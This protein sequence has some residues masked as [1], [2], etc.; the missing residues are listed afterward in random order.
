MAVEASQWLPM[1]CSLWYS[2]CIIGKTIRINATSLPVYAYINHRF[3]ADGISIAPP[4]KFLRKL[5]DAAL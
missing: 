2:F 4:V 1:E 5:A 3:T